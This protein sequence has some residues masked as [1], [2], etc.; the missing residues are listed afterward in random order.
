MS[1]KKQKIDKARLA[2]AKVIHAVAFENA[3]SNESAAFHLSSLGSDTRDKSFASA[4]IY[5]TLSYLPLIDYYI[6]QASSRPL[7]S[8]DPSVLTVLRMGT[9]QLYF[10]Y[11]VPPR[12]AVDESVKLVRFLSG[13][14]ATGFVN[15]IMR[16]LTRQKPELPADERQALEL[17]LTQ[18]LFEMLMR[19]YGEE[20]AISIGQNSLQSPAYVP[21]RMNRMKTDEFNRWA[22]SEEAKTLRLRK[23]V[24]PDCAYGLEPGGTDVTQLRAYRDGLFSLQSQSAMLVGALSGVEPDDRVLDLCAA[25]G[26]KLSHVAELKGNVLGLVACDQSEERLLSLIEMMERLGFGE[27]ERHCLDAT[28]HRDVFDDLFDLVLCDVPCTGLG[29]L[30]RRPEIRSR[31]TSETVER[32]LPIQRAILA[33]GSKAVVSGGL[34]MYSTCTINPEENEEQVRAF[35]DSD[36]G[37]AFELVHLDIGSVGNDS[38]NHSACGVQQMP[39]SLLH[40]QLPGTLL[41]LPHVCHSD[42][43]FIALMRRTR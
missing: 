35:L 9:W 30:Q 32:L 37:V 23:L 25:P 10:S 29:L 11:H 1:P 17:G 27:I 16:K 21:I 42:G 36:E 43:F 41:L 22:D 8:L 24:W 26:G 33:N 3:F 14:R 2:A 7:E 28:V 31:V 34:L 15:A 6:A 5:G 18:E 40:V 13:E 12:A 19:W 39:E 20:H 38:E 4:L